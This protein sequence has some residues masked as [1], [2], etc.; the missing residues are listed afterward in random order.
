[1]A[2]GTETAARSRALVLAASRRAQRRDGE[3]GILWCL[4]CCLVLPALAP[5]SGLTSRKPGVQCIE[6]G[7]QAMREG[8]GGWVVLRSTLRY[9]W[10]RRGFCGTTG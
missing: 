2:L 6:D 4:R 7:T 1:M 5:L 8:P 10:G 3:L 9:P